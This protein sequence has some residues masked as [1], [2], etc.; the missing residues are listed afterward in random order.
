M[1]YLQADGA[2]HLDCLA[3][4]AYGQ[5]MEEMCWVVCTGARQMDW[6]VGKAWGTFFSLPLLPSF[7]VLPYLCL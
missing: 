2:V 1:R 7:L 5:A 3:P 6:D 4:A